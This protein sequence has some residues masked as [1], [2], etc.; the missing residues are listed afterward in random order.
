[1]SRVELSHGTVHYRASGEGA[2][3]VFLHGYLMGARLWDPVTDLLEGEFRC[4]VPDLPFGAHP[5]PMRPGRATRP[6]AAYH[7]AG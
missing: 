4:L 1:M 6:P 2:P 5:A 7:G 3:I